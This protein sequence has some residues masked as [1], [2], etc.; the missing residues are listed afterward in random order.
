MAYDCVSG[1][2]DDNAGGSCTRIQRFSTPDVQY[3]GRPLGTSK[4]NCARSLNDARTVVAGYFPHRDD[5]CSSDS[6]CTDT[7][8]DECLRGTCGGG[9]CQYDDICGCSTN[10]ECT[11]KSNDQCLEG[12]CG[13]DGECEFRDIC[14]PSDG[15][16]GAGKVWVKIAVTRD[17]YPSETSWRF[18]NEC[19]GDVALD[20]GQNDGSA[21][22]TDAISEDGKR[23]VCVDES[24][25]Y[26]FTIDDSYSDGICCSWGFGSYEIEVEGFTEKWTGGSFDS[27]DS[28]LLRIGSCITDQPTTSPSKPPTKS[29]TKPPTQSPSKFPTKPPTRSPTYFPTK[30]PT[31]S[32]SKFPT[33][34]P[35]VSPSNFPTRS[36]TKFPTEL[37][38]KKPSHFP[39]LRQ[40]LVPSISNGPSVSPQ[41]SID[42]CNDNLHPFPVFN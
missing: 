31:K 9:R 27:S 32:P 36:Q 39:S 12:I 38:T 37:P 22:V 30:P 28:K 16:C 41:P 5:L 17:N 35:T 19:T 2:C 21:M 20:R 24:F 3:E 18:V 1:Q 7:G 11:E 4:E 15:V 29:P 10:V 14:E 42:Y 23:F 34:P 25:E 33:K 8:G 26:S 40:T 13:I 6:E